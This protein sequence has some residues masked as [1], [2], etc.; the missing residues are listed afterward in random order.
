MKK[1]NQKNYHIYICVGL[2]VAVFLFYTVIQSLYI[3]NST[4]NYTNAIKDEIRLLINIRNVGN[5]ELAKNFALKGELIEIMK[6]QEY[7]KLY[8]KQFFSLACEYT[9]FENVAIHI[10]DKDG[11]NRYLS[12]THKSLGKNVLGVRKDIARLIKNPHP[13]MEISVGK[14]DITMKGIIPIYDHQKNFLGL[15]ETI[16]HFTPISKYLREENIYS[17]VIIDKKFTKQL[18][19]PY[20][21][22]FV[23][24][25]NVSNTDIRPE[26]KYLLKKHSVEHLISIDTHEFVPAKGRILDGYFVVSIPITDSQGET[27]GYFLAFIYDNY[28]LSQMGFSLHLSMIVMTLLFGLMSYFGYRESGR[29]KHLIEHLDR[30]VKKETKA[31][32]NVTYIDQLTGAYTKAKLR[33][34][35]KEF[36]CDRNIVLL[37]VKNFSQINKTYGFRVGDELLRICVERIERLLARKIYRPHNDELVFLSNDT[38]N[39]I[40]QIRDSFMN[41]P[42]RITELDLNMRVNFAAGITG[43]G[44]TEILRELSIAVNEA[45]KYPSK[46]F[47]YYVSQ[48]I[49]TEVY[50]IS[51]YLH[52][53]IFT[54]KSAHIVPY[55]QEIKNNSSSRFVKYEALARLEVEGKVYTP[56]YF[57]DAAKNSGFLF[58]MTKIVID[59]SFSFLAKQPGNAALSVNITEADLVTHE[60]SDYLLC[61]L[62][63]YN[64]AAERIMLEILEGVTTSGAKNSIKQLKEL[65]SLGFRLAIDDF[66]VEYSNFERI[67]DLDIDF[68]KIDGKYIRNIDT[69]K[70]SYTIAK[71]ITDF[72]HS[73]GIEVIA[74]FVENE[75]IQEIVTSLGIEYSQ[76]YYFSRPEK[77]I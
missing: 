12:W 20:S 5:F 77:R 66:G 53:A 70:K 48:E 36:D 76:G 27:L 52:D 15:I 43:A 25:Y 34:D 13:T 21:S 32:L 9:D 22:L 51:N 37:N 67:N 73:L 47:V 26:I 71:A 17:A 59:K 4:S 50:T 56:F 44:G 33:A 10:V 19:H 68:I 3:K 75:N 72:A 55:F 42:V 62:S 35:R 8:D 54:Q 11:V 46:P 29:N 57:L 31:K 24:G 40:K 61:K 6:N 58:E 74:E 2:F 30:E 23:Q 45:K 38:E 49:N 69:N 60:L 39:E 28:E 63:E 14:F 65:K 7:E 18:V 64:L 16:S 41:E 1:I